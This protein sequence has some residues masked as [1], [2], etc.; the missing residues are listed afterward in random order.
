[1]NDSFSVKA[2]DIIEAKLLAHPD[3]GVRAIVAMFG[4]PDE[5][6]ERVAA[7]LRAEAQALADMP[8]SQIDCSDIPETTDWSNAVR[9]RF[10]AS[11]TLPRENAKRSRAKPSGPAPEGG[12][13]PKLSAMRPRSKP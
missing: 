3:E 8:D 12:D 4:V 2:R 5:A 6:V 11:G 13:A 7:K 9:G 10:T 1:M